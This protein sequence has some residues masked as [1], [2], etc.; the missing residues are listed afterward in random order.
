MRTVKHYMALLLVGF[1]ALF[2]STACGH[3]E[4]EW[5]QAQRDISKLKADLDVANKRH[6]EDDQ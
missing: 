2:F 5:Q 4:D 1:A 3:S 6:T